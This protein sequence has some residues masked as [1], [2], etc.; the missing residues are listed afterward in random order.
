MHFLRSSRG[1]FAFILLFCLLLPGCLVRRRIVKPAG[2]KV[3]KP[4][5]S[6]SKEDLI[7]RLRQ[8]SDSAK[9]FTLKIDM[10]PSVGSLYGGQV[11]DYPTISGFI[12]FKQPDSIRVVG[13][14]PVIHATAF[15]MVSTGND[16]RVSI[17][18]KNQFIEGRN[19]SPATSKNKLENLRPTAFLNALFIPPPNP[20]SEIIL[21]EDD[22]DETK[23]F[24]I[25]K[26]VGHRDNEYFTIRNI[27][28]DRYTL[29]ITRQ[30][31]FDTSGNILGETRYTDWA[32]HNGIAF[33]STIDMERPRDGYEVVIKVTDAKF[34]AGDMTPEKF[35]L[36]PPA[37]AQIKHLE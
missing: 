10:S 13:L 37:G 22:T 6:A 12:L 8:F 16:F 15:D 18:S 14:D 4:L 21:M 28:F 26:T 3:P 11:T 23:A 34:N 7:Q 24:Y 33:P 17:P 9:S 5:L 19:D 20:K 1:R 31:T 27:Y 36:N 30:K 35:V 29:Q 25:L 32:P 2:Q